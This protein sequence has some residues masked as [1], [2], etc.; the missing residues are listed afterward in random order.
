MALVP[1][2]AFGEPSGLRL[3]YAASMDNLDEALG[4]IERGLQALG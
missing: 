1:G 4:R 2:E 3:S